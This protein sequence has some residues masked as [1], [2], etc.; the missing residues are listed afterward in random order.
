MIAEYSLL[1][2]C[3]KASLWLA[4]RYGLDSFSSKELDLLTQAK[5]S[6]GNLLL[7]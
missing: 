6:T 7:K 4:D 3:V 5:G 2:E 1:E